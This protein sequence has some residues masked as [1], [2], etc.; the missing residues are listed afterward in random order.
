MSPSKKAGKKATAVRRATTKAEPATA[1]LDLA[2][3]PVKTKL[4]READSRRKAATFM[5]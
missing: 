5:A 2:P 3:S 4:G 1:V